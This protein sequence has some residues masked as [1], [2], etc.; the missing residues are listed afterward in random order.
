LL[1]MGL[2]FSAVGTAEGQDTKDT[3]AQTAGSGS[4]SSAHVQHRQNVSGVLVSITATSLQLRTKAN[5]PQ[6][7]AKAPQA[8]TKLVVFVI[9]PDTKVLA[10]HTGDTIVV[11]YV[12]DQSRKLAR[13]VQEANGTVRGVKGTPADTG[14]V[15]SVNPH[16]MLIDP[17]T[18]GPS[19]KAAKSAPQVYA[20]SAASTVIL[21]QAHSSL[22]QVA[23]T[24]SDKAV[25]AT[26]TSAK[27]AGARVGAASSGWTSLDANS[28]KHTPVILYRPMPA[29]T[30]SAREK[31]IEGT[32]ALKADFRASGVVD[33][34]GV[35]LPLGYGLDD[36]AIAAA[37]QIK[38]TPAVGATGQPVD[39]QGI[40]VVN[41]L[42]GM[43]EEQNP[44]Q[45]VAV[46]NGQI[47]I[48]HGTNQGLMV[49]STLQIV[50]KKQSGLVDAATGKP[51]AAEEKVG[52][53][54]VTSVQDNSASATFTGSQNPE[55]GDLVRMREVKD[56]KK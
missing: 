37:R 38:F 34:L 20:A 23:S 13:L 36:S 5:A 51:N 53:A 8:G 45:V 2:M 44:G 17:H 4:A 28:L 41:F 55:V 19:G 3:K 27:V 33:V 35:E 47:V 30:M 16:L 25:D 48:N 18:T 52:E 39:W 21:A 42:L 50:R 11:T 29:Y 26:A 56:Q 22:E 43:D 7:G 6:A 31:K 15:A 12:V 32:V 9:S 14:G 49:G 46:D 10:V 54:V 24:A 1:S 40:V